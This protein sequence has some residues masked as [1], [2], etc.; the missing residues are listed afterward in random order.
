MA[1]IRFLNAQNLIR[2]T[3]SP[4][5]KNL[6]TLKFPDTVV[7]N[8]SGFHVFLDVAGEEDIGGPAYEGFTTLFR[9]DEETHKYKGYQL[10]NDGRVYI[11]PE[12]EPEPEP[13]VPTLDEVKEHKISE[14]N[15]AQ[16]AMIQAG[17]NVTLTDGREEHF[18]LTDHDQASLTGLQAKEL[19]GA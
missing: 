12:P 15:D 18:T 19:Q 16:Q 14:M 7:V 4:R 6:V 11:S 9:N 10:S 13:Y 8:T 3:V 2:C 5:G 1:F 17:I